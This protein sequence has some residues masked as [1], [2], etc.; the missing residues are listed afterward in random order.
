MAETPRRRIKI[1]I[2]KPVDV[3]SLIMS[4]ETD[5]PMGEQSE[6]EEYAMRYESSQA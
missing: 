2:D 6:E 3:S 4:D 5:Q 1:D